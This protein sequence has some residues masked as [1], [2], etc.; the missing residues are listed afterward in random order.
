MGWKQD[1]FA[2]FM[3][4]DAEQD[5]VEE[6]KPV[7]ELAAP[8]APMEPIEAEQNP[9]GHSVQRG[10]ERYGVEVSA[11]TLARIIERGRATLIE[12]SNAFK[13]RLIYDVPVFVEGLRDPIH[14]RVVYL[15][16]KPGMKHGLIMTVLPPLPEMVRRARE[17][18]EKL[19]A[20]RLAKH[21]RQSRVNA[22]QVACAR[23]G[24]KTRGKKSWAK[25][26]RQ[27]EA[28]DNEF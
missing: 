5:S 10:I 3:R 1:L 28:E 21:A 18:R 4:A 17:A 11:V 19:N 22:I 16:K 25:N 26:Y 15:P 8:A 12:R 13:D 27:Q 24:P 6:A 2:G 20:R 23:R 9:V 14:I 7:E